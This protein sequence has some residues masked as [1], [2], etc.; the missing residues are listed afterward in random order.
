MNVGAYGPTC[1]KSI[2]IPGNIKMSGKTDIVKGRI[3]EAAGVLTDND[4]L[5]ASGRADQAT[6]NV[7]AAAAKA[8][9][10]LKIAV[11]TTVDRATLAGRKAM[12]KARASSK[13]LRD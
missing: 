8:A 7:K 13:K 12:D 5:R 6:G 11:H 1:V 9:T 2:F 3:K 10:K 4:K